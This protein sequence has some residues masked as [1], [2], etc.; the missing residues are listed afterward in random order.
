MLVMKTTPKD[1]FLNLGMIVVLYWVMT[2]VIVVLFGII[3]VLVPDVSSYAYNGISRFG[4]AS[5]VV[6]F[7][8]LVLLIRALNKGITAEPERANLPV[9]RWLAYFT[10]F[11]AGLVAAGDLIVVLYSMLGGELTTRFILKVLV[12]FAVSGCVFWYLLRELRRN[13]SAPSR[14]KELTIGS[15]AVMLAVV[16]VAIALSGTP[17]VQRD[18]SFD[19][20]RIYAL[21]D[22]EQRVIAYY[23]DN[24]ALPESSEAFTDAVGNSTVQSDPETGMPFVYEKTSALTF[25]LCATF[26][27]SFD[28]TPAEWTT[29]YDRGV[30]KQR[31]DHPAGDHCFERT[32]DPSK[33]KANPD[34]KS[35]FGI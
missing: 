3:N 24:Q 12:V 21:Q 26:G 35:V 34:P 5:I 22:M 30:V 18:A 20:Q 14:D 16:A 13:W 15:S 10:I 25:K 32:I 8:V 6:L 9:R 23:A 2:S 27:V 29:N 1:F 33:V 31:W 4:V 7:P 28:D 19:L 11:V 17:G